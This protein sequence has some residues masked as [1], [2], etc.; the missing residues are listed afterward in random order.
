MNNIDK[1]LNGINSLTKEI[2]QLNRQPI[3]ISVKIDDK[4]LI[5]VT[6]NRANERS[7]LEKTTA[8]KPQ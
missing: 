6:A 2:I 5:A 1:V 8:Y 7:N 3:H 4:E